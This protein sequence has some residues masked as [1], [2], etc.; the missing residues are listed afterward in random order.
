MP[1]VRF[2][3]GIKWMTLRRLLKDVFSGNTYCRVDKEEFYRKST[4]FSKYSYN[5]DVGNRPCVI[6]VMTLNAGLIP[7]QSYVEER[8]KAICN[9]IAKY[10]IV[11][12]QVSVVS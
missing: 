3:V 5:T 6:H 10:D 11:I 12:L 4:V 2:A 1:D 7:V 9:L 8:C